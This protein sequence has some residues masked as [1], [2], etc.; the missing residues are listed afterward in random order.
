MPAPPTSPSGRAAPSSQRGLLTER[1]ARQLEHDI[2]SGEIPVGEKLPS[3]RELAERF[4]ASRNVVREALRRLEAQHMIE[5]AP[6]RGSFVSEQSPGQARSYDALYRAGRPTVRHLIE[7]R[8]P[9]EVE[10]VGLATERADEAELDAMRRANDALLR[11]TDVVHKARAD[12]DFHDAIAAASGNPVLRTMLSSIGGMMF[13]MMLR[14]NSDPSIGEPGVPHHPEILE[15]IVARDVELARARM[16]EHLM[17][18]LRTYGADLD[19]GLDVM[20]RQ[21]IET[22]LRQS[23]DHG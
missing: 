22:L 16:R 9:L 8:I 3:E 23:Q 18:G 17:L 1:V 13:E 6:G 19:L 11:A 15:A 20:A 12:L 21:H 7:A 5:V 10:I 14:S 2:R 4:G